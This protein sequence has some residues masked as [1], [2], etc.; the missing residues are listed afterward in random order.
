MSMLNRALGM[1]RML[2]DAR[3]TE[4]VTVGVYKD[5]TDETTGDPTRVLVEEHYS[6]KGR[7]KYASISVSDSSEPSQIVAVQEPLLSV[8][9]GSPA[10]P[11]G[12][13]VHVT[14]STADSSLVGR[15]YRVEGAPQ[16]GQTT[17]HRYQLKQLS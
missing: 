4:T 5:G 15:T 8:P 7:I 3:M 10:V 17:S 1:G 12:D 6:G 13:E 16:A 9:T 11:V 14:A 2:A